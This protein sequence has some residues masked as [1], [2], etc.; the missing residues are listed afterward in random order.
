VLKNRETTVTRHDWTQEEVLALLNTPFMDLLFHA[1]T[2][3]RANHDPNEIQVS[4]LLNIKT[5]G[6][7][8]DCSYCGQSAHHETLLAKTRLTP[9]EEVLALAQQAKANGATRFCMGAAWRSPTERDLMPVL[10]MIRGVKALGLETCVTLGMITG[11]QAQQLKEAGLDYY[12]HNLDTG[13]EFYGQI[14]TTRTYQDRLDTLAQ[15]RTHGLRLCCGGILGLGEN[16]ED[17]ASLLVQL[18]NLPVH[19]ESVPINLLVHVE[20]TPLQDTTPPDLFDLVRTIAVARILMPKS[21]VRLAAGRA[22]MSDELQTLCFLAGANSVFYGERLLTT[23]NV[24]PTQDSV[25][26]ERLNLHTKMNAWDS[27]PHACYMD[28]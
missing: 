1:Q 27:N 22:Q 16:K 12:N 8:E 7:P 3:H 23:P 20:G 10:E 4:T 24:D 21:F 18:A 17:R 2:I 25:L 6:C 14:V 13:P 19:P 15:V 5:G 11:A 9:L 26:F 28:T